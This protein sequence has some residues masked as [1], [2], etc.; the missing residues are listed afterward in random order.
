MTVF[1][2]TS[3]Q[4][5]IIGKLV[6]EESMKKRLLKMIATHAQIAGERCGL[7]ET[8]MKEIIRECYEDMVSRLYN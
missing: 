8:E 5:R 4:Y 1:P 2:T 6:R 3:A 7:C